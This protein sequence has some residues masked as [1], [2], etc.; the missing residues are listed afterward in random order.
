[1]IRIRSAIVIFIRIEGII[2]PFLA[3]KLKDITTLIP[4]YGFSSLA[5]AFERGMVSSSRTMK[6]FCN[7]R[8]AGGG[9]RLWWICT[10][11][12]GKLRIWWDRNGLG[13]HWGWSFVLGARRTFEWAL[14]HRLLLHKSL[15]DFRLTAFPLEGE[16]TLV[17]SLVVHGVGAGTL[18]A[19]DPTRRGYR[20]R[21]IGMCRGGRSRWRW[22]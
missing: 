10:P 12:S 19:T 6:P 11:R 9:D 8:W 13:R 2:F 16:W 3:V 22:N 17:F 7:E 4:C 15:V 20:K 18:L 14:C 5:P 1:V 21:D